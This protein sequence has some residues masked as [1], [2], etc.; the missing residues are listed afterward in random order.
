MAIGW[1]IGFLL[2]V[3]VLGWR[4][5]PPRGDN[6]AGC[7]GMTIGLIVFLQRNGL[8]G[9]TVAT[10]VCGFVGGFGFATA[11]LL[12][13]MEVKSGWQVNWHSVLEQTYGFVNGIGV[14]IAIGYLAARTPKRTD[15]PSA[16][17][18]S[19]IFA[20]AF[21]LL[22]VTYLNFRKNPEAWAKAK[23]M[24]ETMYG[25]PLSG[26]FVPAKGWMGWF[27]LA[28]LAIATAVI[29]L[30]VCHRRRSLAI[31]PTTW[32]G[33]SQ[34]LYLGFLWWVVIGNFERALVAFSPQ[35]L[36][37][38]GVIYLNAVICTVLMM[39]HAK[40][41]EKLVREASQLYRRPLRII[42][43]AGIAGM[44]LSVLLDWGIVRARYED[45]FAG[46]A[47]LHIRF[48]PNATAT[49]EKPETGKPHP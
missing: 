42:T 6:W 18:W 16:R 39:M 28:Y 8:S 11:T 40:P 46:H 43:T 7:V 3:V 48:G 33:K 29:G 9:V 23:A 45:Q 24:P 4:M 13:L 44:I 47:G 27:E 21:V 1:W 32:L 12:K 26:W 35:R 41:A 38:E 2:L 17:Q 22:L 14:A 5:T 19:D 10:L 49:K 25:I 20:V 15:E 34:F 36:A 31:V 37:T 30:M